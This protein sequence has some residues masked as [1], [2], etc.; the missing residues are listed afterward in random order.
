MANQNFTGAATFKIARDGTAQWEFTAEGV[1]VDYQ[2]FIAN[3]PEQGRKTSFSIA[4]LE[5]VEKDATYEF[6]YDKLNVG[7]LSYSRDGKPYDVFGTV[8]VVTSKGGDRQDIEVDGTFEIDYRTFSIKGTGY[9]E[10]K[11]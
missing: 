1:L 6:K 8:K 11:L 5:S 10:F 3:G 9:S 7:Y 4:Y 2:S